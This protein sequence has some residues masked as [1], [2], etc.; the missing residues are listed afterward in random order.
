MPLSQIFRQRPVPLFEL[1]RLL[2]KP[3]II[4][5]QDCSGRF[6]NGPTRYIQ[7][8]PPPFGT[9]PAAFFYLILDTCLVSIVRFFFFVDRP[10]PVC[11]DLCQAL[12]ACCESN[13]KFALEVIQLNRHGASG[14]KRHIHGFIALIRRIRP[15]VFQ[16]LQ[17]G[18]ML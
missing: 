10:K 3:C 13:H 7:C 11:A 16:L 5:V 14:Y 2:F 8:L 9:V 4:S 18:L 15:G 12:Y 6:L 17:A 1:F